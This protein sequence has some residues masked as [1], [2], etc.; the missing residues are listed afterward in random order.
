M[1]KRFLFLIPDHFLT[2]PHY[3]LTILTI[4]GMAEP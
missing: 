1:V 2:C 4:P 3:F